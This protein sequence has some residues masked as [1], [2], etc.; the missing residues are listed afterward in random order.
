M[1]THVDEIDWARVIERLLYLFPPVIGVGIVGILREAEP[2]VPGLQLG[3][4]LIG[5]FGYTFLTLGLLVAIFFDAR[6]I[7]RRPGVSGNWNPNPW[8]NAIVT[9]VSAP[10]A[11]VV[12]LARRH[13][14]FGT[15]PGWSGWWLVVAISLATTLFGFAAAIVAIVFTLPVLL[16]A[17]VGL[18]GAIAFGSFPIAIHQDAAY[19]C[20]N[21]DS[22]RPN[23]GLYLGIAFLSLSIPPLQ[24]IVA[25]Y[26]LVRRRRTMDD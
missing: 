23:P 3:L 4:L 16:R 19:V 25:G 2:G 9:L 20:T 18:A 17:A 26:Y 8:L 14:R 13:R 7:R 5:S 24:P 22:W 21:G 10:L 15:R 12:Y 6:R 11:G 1:A